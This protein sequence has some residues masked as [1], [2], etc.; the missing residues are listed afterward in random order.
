M[1]NSSP[2][3]DDFSCATLANSASAIT[4]QLPQNTRSV[5][6][7]SDPSTNPVDDCEPQLG[8]IASHPS[9]A[10]QRIANRRS[11]RPR[12]R[13]P[14]MGDLKFLLNKGHIFVGYAQFVSRR[15]NSRNKA[16]SL[17]LDS[18][19][20]LALEEVSHLTKL[21]QTESVELE[22]AVSA[23]IQPPPLSKQ[24]TRDEDTKTKRRRSAK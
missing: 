17:L 22:K 3:R 2:N 9:A 12:S 7:Y 21:I 10:P 24:S 4:N 13:S 16:N 11:N 14:W 18:E 8:R 23:V 19:D 6:A 20:M 1:T 15:L 5:Q